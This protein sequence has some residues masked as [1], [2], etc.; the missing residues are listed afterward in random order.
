[1]PLREISSELTSYSNSTKMHEKLTKIILLRFLTLFLG[2]G[3]V[4]Y[5]SRDVIGT[6]VKYFLTGTLIL[7]AASFLTVPSTPII[8]L[9]LPALELPEFPTFGDARINVQDLGP[10]LPEGKMLIVL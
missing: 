8:P 7:A 9:E 10:N 1:M 5:D 2:F 3:T 6:Y 4:T